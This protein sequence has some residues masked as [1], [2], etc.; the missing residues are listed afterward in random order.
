MSGHTNKKKKKKFEFA[1]RDF[2]K[3]LLKTNL[4]TI[5]CMMHIHKNL[6]ET[7]LLQLSEDL[8]KTYH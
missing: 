8:S 5:N 3:Q 7:Y 6:V 2:V 4:F 1:V